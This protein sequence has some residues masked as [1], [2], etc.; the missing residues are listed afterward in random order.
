MKKGPALHAKINTHDDSRYISVANEKAAL[1]VA[2]AHD[3]VSFQTVLFEIEEPG[4]RIVQVGAESD[5]RYVGVEK[6]YTLYDIASEFKAMAALPVSEDM[7]AFE[8][9]RFKRMSD[10]FNDV[11]T[12]CGIMN[13]D[14]AKFV[15]NTRYDTLLASPSSFIALKE[16]M[17]AFDGHGQ[18]I[19]PSIQP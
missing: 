17:K 2:L 14:E 16:G 5:L 13:M 11:A 3:A 9:G 18:Q 8:K 7:S 19:W 10:D 15:R 4:S 6:L 12:L 1:E